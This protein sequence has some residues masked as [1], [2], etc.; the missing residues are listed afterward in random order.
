[1]HCYALL[2]TAVHC[3]ALLCTAIAYLVLSPDILRD[4]FDHN[5]LP[6]HGLEQPSDNLV[7]AHPRHDDAA[8][9]RA[10]EPKYSNI[11]ISKQHAKQMSC[12]M[13]VKY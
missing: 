10:E 4:D 9:R 12:M 2:C 13:P 7:G 11:N 8:T 1:M 6:A 5:T 3:Y